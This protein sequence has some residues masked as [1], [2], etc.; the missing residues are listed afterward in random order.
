M[1][2]EFDIKDIERG[3]VI[4]AMA[5]QLLS[6]WASHEGEDTRRGRHE[7]GESLR[8]AVSERITKLADEVVRKAF[9][10]EIKQRISAAIDTVLAEGWYETDN[11]GSRK[12]ERIDLKG[13]IGKLLTEARGDNYNRS[14]SLL[15]ERLEA[16]IKTSLDKEFAPV[17]AEAKA[18]LRER[19]DTSV[20]KTVADT[21]KSALGLK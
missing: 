5:D 6:R 13:R 4:D 9:D 7:L 2:I 11:Y 20:M 15:A 1:K 10:A 21:I 14:A 18:T 3:E 16:N 8:K 19:L 17:I 12:G